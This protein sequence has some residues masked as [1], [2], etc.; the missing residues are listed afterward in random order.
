MKN[1]HVSTSQQIRHL[2]KKKSTP[3]TLTVLQMVFFIHHS[4]NGFAI[5][6]LFVFII[7]LLHILKRNRVAIPQAKNNDG[8][9]YEGK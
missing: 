8:R 6:Y 3:F 4:E 2:A 9:I 1:V 7:F 5:F